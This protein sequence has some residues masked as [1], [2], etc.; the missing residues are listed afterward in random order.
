MEVQSSH[1]LCASFWFKGCHI[2]GNQFPEG[3]QKVNV[4]VY[5]VRKGEEEGV[6]EG[7]RGGC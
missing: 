7:G 6:K 1:Q 2:G 5:T 4:V 3:E